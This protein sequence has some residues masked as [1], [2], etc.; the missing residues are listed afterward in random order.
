VRAEVKFTTNVGLLSTLVVFAGEKIPAEAG[1]LS[2][3]D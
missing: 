1:N 2:A 3:G